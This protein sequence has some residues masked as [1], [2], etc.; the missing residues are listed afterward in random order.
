MCE[1]GSGTLDWDAII[2]ACERTGVQWAMVEQDWGWAGDD[3]F[4]SLKIS[5]D[6]LTT[7]GFI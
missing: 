4:N 5:Y 1:I 2:D 3:P 6:Y 7:K